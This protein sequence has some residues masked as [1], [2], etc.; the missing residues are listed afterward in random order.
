MDDEEKNPR[1][2]KWPWFVL[3]A[4]LLFV[5]LAI[6]AV[7]IAAKKV[8]QERGVNVPAPAGTN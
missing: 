2:Y 4:V 8:E 5:T 1:R 3:A 6:L 7:G